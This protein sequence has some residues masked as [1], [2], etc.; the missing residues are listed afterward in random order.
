MERYIESYI[1]EMEAFI[2][3]VQQDQPPPVTGVDGRIPVVMGYA[4]R[5]SYEENRPVR[6]SEIAPTFGGAS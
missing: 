2:E 1:A 5:K 6:L 3:C 4:A